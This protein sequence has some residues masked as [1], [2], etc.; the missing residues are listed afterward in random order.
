MGPMCSTNTYT[1]Y[2][3]G[4]GLVSDKSQGPHVQGGN[5]TT[6]IERDMP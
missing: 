3:Q 1:M 5:Y 6:Y 2:N 4:G